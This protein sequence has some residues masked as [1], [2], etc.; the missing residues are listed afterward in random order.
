MLAKLRAEE[1]ATVLAE[2]G[3]NDALD[4]ALAKAL[5]D[6]LAEASVATGSQTKSARVAKHR[7]AIEALKSKGWT[8]KQIAEKITAGGLPVSARTVRLEMTRT[9]AAAGR[10]KSGSDGKTNRRQVAKKQTQ[11]GKKKGT[12]VA[13]VEVK[14]LAAKPT[15]DGFFNAEGV[16]N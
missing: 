6:A 2:E 16:E 13:T 8:W 12:A 4:S 1:G 15:A 11:E 10:A 14:P 7:D 3:T 9:A 5:A